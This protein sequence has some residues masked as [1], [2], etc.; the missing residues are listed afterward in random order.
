MPDDASR[1]KIPENGFLPRNVPESAKLTL[2]PS[3]SSTNILRKFQSRQD[4]IKMPILESIRLKD[5]TSK[6][7]PP[8]F[9]SLR[10][11]GPTVA[12]G[13]DKAKVAL[14]SEVSFS[15]HHQNADIKQELSVWL[16]LC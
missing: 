8:S 7:R 1:V 14:K 15:T 4:T 6:R 2:A 12:A 11:S 10:G 5:Q 9:S 3:S 13:E 16:V